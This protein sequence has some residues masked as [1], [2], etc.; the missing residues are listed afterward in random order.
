MIA[1]VVPPAFVNVYRV[2]APP[3]PATCKSA[4]GNELMATTGAVSTVTVTVDVAVEPPDIAV[5]VYV[6]LF[7]GVT[8]TVPAAG[9]APT[10]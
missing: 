5:K 9:S 10:P 6:V 4:P 8:V 1:V 7:D 2:V 3:L